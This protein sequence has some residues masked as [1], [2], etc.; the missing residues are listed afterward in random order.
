LRKQR[1]AK[2]RRVLRNEILHQVT[3]SVSL[4]FT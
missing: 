2:K 3:V 1:M 4:Q